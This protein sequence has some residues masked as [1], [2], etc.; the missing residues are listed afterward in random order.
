MRILPDPYIL[1]FLLADCLVLLLCYNRL[2][3]AIQGGAACF[4]SYHST[5]EML[6]NKYLCT[7]VR[8]IL[9][10]L[11]PLYAMT[12]TFTGLSTAGF[13]WTLA[14]LVALLLFRKAVLLLLGWLSSRQSAFRALERTGYAVAVLG[15]F[16]SLLAALAVWLA[17]ALP[18]WLTWGWLGLV[19][20]VCVFFYIWRGNS[21]I[22]STG[23]SVFYW[24]L[25]L[26]TLEFLP[27]CVVV[28]ILINGD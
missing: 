20:L 3:A 1:A 17:P 2:L 28:N 7:S 27:I 8:I 19:A 21:I 6:G 26:C 10:I 4:H 12:L 22:L 16:V 5:L 23:F 15:M 9:L 24:V 18:H 25:Y 13:A 14:A 11:L